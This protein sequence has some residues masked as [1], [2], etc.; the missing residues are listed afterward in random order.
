MKVNLY[1]RKRRAR[2]SGTCTNLMDAGVLELLQEKVFVVF[3]KKKMM[4][5]NFIP[6]QRPNHGSMLIRVGSMMT[7]R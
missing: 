1:T 7:K 6:H 4:V 5:K 2:R 3:Y